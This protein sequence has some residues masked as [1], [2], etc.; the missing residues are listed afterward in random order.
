R[1]ALLLLGL[2]A[3]AV[4]WP[5]PAPPFRL[6][7]HP[8]GEAASGL[9]MGLGIVWG[10]AAAQTPAVPYS[11]FWAAAPLALLTAGILHANNARDRSHDAAVGKSTL[12]TRLSA[13]AVVLEYRVLVGC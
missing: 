1:P 2:L 4:G 3:L 6:A 5:Y 10:T 12:A 8:L 9:P 7:Y 11:V 13:R